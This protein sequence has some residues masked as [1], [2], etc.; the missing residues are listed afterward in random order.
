MGDTSVE[1][2]VY[3][4]AASQRRRRGVPDLVGARRARAAAHRLADAV[5]TSRS[6]TNTLSS[7]HLSDVDFKGPHADVSDGKVEAYRTSASNMAIG[8][9]HVR[10][11]DRPGLGRRSRAAGPDQLRPLLRGR[12]LQRRLG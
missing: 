2:T 4:E 9:A 3:G 8:P 7:T 10:H 5:S 1:L 12:V 6:T 11:P